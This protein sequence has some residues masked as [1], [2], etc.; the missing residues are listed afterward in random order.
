MDHAAI[1]SQDLFL[2]EDLRVRFV[3]VAEASRELCFVTFDS[4]NDLGTLARPAFAEGFLLS[5]GIPAIHILSRRNLWY[6]EPELPDALAAA[7]AIAGGYGRVIAYGSS[8]GGFAAIRFGAEAGAGAAIA[9]SP[10]FSIDPDEVDFEPRWAKS[11]SHIRFLG[12]RRD[13]PRVGRVYVFYDPFD[14]D[15]QHVSRIAAHYPTTRIRLPYAGHPA[16]GY[17]NETG[18]LPAA[19]ESIASDSLDAPAF[20]RAARAIRH[21]SGQY[22]FNMARR[23]P[24]RRKETKHALA[25]RAVAANTRD[26]VNRSFLAMVLD[27]MGAWTEAEA[28]HRAALATE[29][30][31]PHFLERYAR[32]LLRHGRLAEAEPL[33]G[34]AYGIAPQIPFV[35]RT[36]GLILLAQGRSGD[37]L[38]VLERIS[39]VY[40]EHLT[41][42]IPDAL[43][44]AV[45]RGLHLIG[46]GR[47]SK[48][49]IPIP[50]GAELAWRRQ[51]GRRERAAAGE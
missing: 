20:E 6:Q 50:F 27:Q 36:R 15:G 21:R 18:F 13:A 8:M 4:F 22:L 46:L 11:A 19:I 17:F 45:W 35:A 37:G 43:R 14:L 5:R 9:I 26:P 51:R 25:R 49:A 33:S 28:E 1:A 12:W 32:F 42:L 48:P 34:Q 44:V 31:N 29:P 23:L 16:G 40:P 41:R 10:Q 3:D 2:S 47:R 24:M 30:D 38:R 7:R 39:R